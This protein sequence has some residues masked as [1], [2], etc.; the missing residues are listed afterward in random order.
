MNEQ[1]IKQIMTNTVGLI[2]AEL[3]DAEL[4][5]LN[6]TVLM[7]GDP[8]GRLFDYDKVKSLFTQ[9]NGTKMHEETKEALTRIVNSRL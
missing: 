5:V 8:H 9:D 1:Q 3:T 2:C 4:A 6:L 7:D